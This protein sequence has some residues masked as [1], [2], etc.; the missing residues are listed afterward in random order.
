MIFNVAALAWDTDGDGIVEYHEVLQAIKVICGG[1]L[2]S[3]RDKLREWRGIPTSESRMQTYKTIEWRAALYG[4]LI[5]IARANNIQTFLVFCL[6]FWPSIIV[7]T[8]VYPCYACSD[9]HLTIATQLGIVL[10][11]QN[12]TRPPDAPPLDPSYNSTANESASVAAPVANA[13]LNASALNFTALAPIYATYTADGYNCSTPFAGVAEVDSVTR[14]APPAPHSLMSQARPG[15]FSLR[16]AWPRDVCP[17]DDDANGLRFLYPECDELLDCELV[18]GAEKFVPNATGPTCTRFAPHPITGYSIIDYYSPS[19]AT[20]WSN[21][22]LVPPW[23]PLP[24]GRALPATKCVKDITYPLP[25]SGFFRFFLLFYHSVVP[26]MVILALIKLVC[27]ACLHMPWMTATRKRNE[28]L[29]RTAAKRKA[30]VRRMTEGGQEFVVKRAAKATGQ[31]QAAEGVIKEITMKTGDSTKEKKQEVGNKF[32]TKFKG[33]DTV[34]PAETSASPTR[35]ALTDQ[36]G[37]GAE[38]VAAVPAAEGGSSSFA[39]ELRAMSSQAE[40]QAP[41]S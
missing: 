9:F 33:G 6:L 30:E 19:E 29:Q 16:D 24:L 20:N 40:A 7:E 13:A 32:L 35:L 18:G 15:A 3:M 14:G 41:A 38:P 36:S 27:R 39:A 37:G 22:S 11:L 5:S 34:L 28:K 25:T 10:G 4:L 23:A 2:L 8:M 12:Y 26:P 21:T 1:W 31:G 17:L